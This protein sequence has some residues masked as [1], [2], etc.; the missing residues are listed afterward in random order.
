MTRNKYRELAPK[1]KWQK[2]LRFLRT[3]LGCLFLLLVGVPGAFIAYLSVHNFYLRTEGLLTEAVV[4]DERNYVGNNTRRF[5]Y[6]YQFAVSG[7]TYTGNSL[8]SH[9]AIGQTIKIKYA[10]NYPRFNEVYKSP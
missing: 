4:I 5:S 2:K 7:V 1:R 9:Y 6:S 10:A 8:S 3:G